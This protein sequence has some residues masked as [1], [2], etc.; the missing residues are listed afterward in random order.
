MR[1]EPDMRTVL[2]TSLTALGLL[3]ASRTAQAQA[4]ESPAAVYKPVEGI[5]QRFGTKLAAGYF[6]PRDGACAVTIFVAENGDTVRTEPVRV[7]LAV[8]PGKTAELSSPE[9]TALQVKCGENAS[10][11]EVRRGQV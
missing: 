4:G 2:A 8:L 10:K 1:K 3:A 7:Q 11:L 6:L 5:S 9:G